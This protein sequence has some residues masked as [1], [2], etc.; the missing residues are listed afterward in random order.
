MTARAEDLKPGD[1]ILLGGCADQ[2]MR[3]VAVVLAGRKRT[4]VHVTIDSGL[5]FSY[6]RRESVVLAAPGT[7]CAR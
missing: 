5:T 3:V 6:R 4:R 2:P 1:V 7:P